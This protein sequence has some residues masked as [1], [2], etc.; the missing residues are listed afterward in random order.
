MAA[1]TG[2]KKRPLPN[3]TDSGESSI[4]SSSTAVP[5]PSKRIALESESTSKP[6]K[7]AGSYLYGAG[8]GTKH[9]TSTGGYLYGSG[10]GNSSSNNSRRFNH[11]AGYHRPPNHYSRPSTTHGYGH[12][13]S[14]HAYT[15][16]PTYPPTQPPQSHSY[17][18]SPTPFGTQRPPVPT[19]TSTLAPVREY[20]WHSPHV[21]PTH[22]Q[23]SQQQ[24]PQTYANTTSPQ[25]YRYPA[26]HEAAHSQQQPSA[27]HIPN[28]DLP[29]T[30]QTPPTYA[31]EYP[32]SHGADDYSAS[33]PY[34]N[35]HAGK[36]SSFWIGVEK[37]FMRKQ[38]YPVIYSFARTHP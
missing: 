28:P 14:L 5:V 4:T 24:P 2:T 1:A 29:H 19:A 35:A 18:Q 27:S 15:R 22:T 9:S 10:H 31:Y 36:R 3:E 34:G 12:L 33:Q 6:Q 11:R 21:R 17:S 23:Q 30:T 16:T 20:R 26:S 25:S 38:L 32:A 37:L 8:H 13:R 7:S